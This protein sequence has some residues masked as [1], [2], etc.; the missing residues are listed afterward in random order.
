[1]GTRPWPVA[2]LGLV[3]A[4]KGGAPTAVQRDAGGGA[5]PAAS[6][7]GSD[8][9]DAIAR[10]IDASPSIVATPIAPGSPPPPGAR[11]GLV[12]VGGATFRDAAGANAV[13][14]LGHVSATFSRLGVIHL[15][16]GRLAI[17]IKDLAE[18]CPTD[19]TEFLARSVDVTDLDADGIAE[20]GFGYRVGCAPDLAL[21]VLVL[22]GGTKYILR[23]TDATAARADPALDRWP[24]GAYAAAQDRYA[25]AA[26]A[27]AGTATADLFAAPRSGD[28]FPTIDLSRTD[29]DVGIEMSYPRLD[30]LPAPAI[31]TLTRQMRDLIGADSYRG[32]SDSS[33]TYYGQCSVTVATPELIGIECRTMNDVLSKADLAAGTGGAPGDYTR[34]MINV[35][36]DPGLPAVDPL[37]LLGDRAA[38]AANCGPF[39]PDQVRFAPDGITVVPGLD[40]TPLDTCTESPLGWDQL[41]PRTPRA[42]AVVARFE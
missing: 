3:V 32:D 22:E 5:V 13:Y 38:L 19:A 27:S 28:D 39:D 11:K 35:W 4:C 21:K 26:A 24:A 33:G 1:M 12:V 2:L 14:L 25:A 15:V 9:S 23:G 18:G 29:G 31:A 37:D 10:A 17:E 16:D 42:R 20:L 30:G 8:S 40:T 41:R 6:G 34:T 7:S 36:L